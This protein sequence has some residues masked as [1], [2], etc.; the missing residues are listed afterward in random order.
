MV[1]AM[2]E[3]GSLFMRPEVLP[4]GLSAALMPPRPYTE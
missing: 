4:A 3:I 2:R 1:P